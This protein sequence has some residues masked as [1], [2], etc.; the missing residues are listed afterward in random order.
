MATISYFVWDASKI[1]F[2]GENHDIN[3]LNRRILY[4]FTIL[5]LWKILDIVARGELYR[6]IP[7]EII[8]DNEQSFFKIIFF[9]Q[10][11]Y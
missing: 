5:E 2:P 9:L 10:R 8:E 1:R 4:F 7:I 3:E 11:I 6:S